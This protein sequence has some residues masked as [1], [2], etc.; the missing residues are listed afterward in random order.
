[1]KMI[2]SV[3]G[4]ID[5]INPVEFVNARNGQ[6]P[7]QTFILDITQDLN[8]KTFVMLELFGDEK[9]SLLKTLAV[10]D[11]VD[12]RLNFRGNKYQKD[13]L[14]T[15][16]YPNFQVWRIDKIVRQG[17]SSAD[18]AAQAFEAEAMHRTTEAK[19]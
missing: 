5:H 7:K 12:C 9:V 19:F 14:L 10:G 3:Q 6:A 18:P 1:M 17:I 8:N 16:V 2:N 4:R 11:M 15:V 13:H